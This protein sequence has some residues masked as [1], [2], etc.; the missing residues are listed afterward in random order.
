VLSI[1]VDES[2]DCGV[3]RDHSLQLIKCLSGGTQDAL[4]LESWGMNK[5]RFDQLG[6]DGAAFLV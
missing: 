2:H 4:P 1:F 3:I 5:S 6:A